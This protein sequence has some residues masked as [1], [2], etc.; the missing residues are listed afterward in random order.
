MEDRID[1]GGYATRNDLKCMDGRTIRKDAFKDCD[2]LTVPLVWQH[3]HNEPGKVLGHAI[4]ENRED[5]VY[6]YGVFNNTEAGQTARELVNNGDVRSLSIYANQLKQRGGD[7]LHGVIREV[8]LVLAG[9][10]PGAYIDDLS[11]GHGDD[12]TDDG[13]AIIYNNET[14]ELQH[15]ADEEEYY[16][17]EEYYP[18][19]EYDNELEHSSNEED[20]NMADRTVADIFNE[21]TDE[22]KNVVY[23]MVGQ[24]MQD[25]DEGDD[26]DMKHNVFEGD[27]PS[28]SLSHADMEMIFAD[29]KRLG[30][31]R[32]AV[33][34]H[35]ESG[36]LAHTIYDRN[37]NEVTYGVADIDYLFPE[38]R[39]LNNPPEFIRR[40]QDWVAKVMSSVH[41]TPFSRIKSQ[42]ANIT[43]D[44]ARAKGYI[45]GKRKKEEVFTLLKRTTDPQ[46]IYKK[47]KLDR[48]D[49]VDITDFDVVAWI[50]GEMRTMLNEELARAF[51]VGDG[52]QTSDEDHISEDHVRPIYHED[53][54]YAIRKRVEE[55][56]DASKTAKN[57]IRAAIKARKDYKG[58]GN[59]TLFTTEDMLTDMLLIED[60]I[61]HLLYPTAAILATTL[62]VKEIVTVPVM[63][64]LETDGK[65]LLGIIVNLTDYNVGADKGGEINM[66]DDFDIDYN[67]QKYLI[68]TRCSGAL[69]K[70]FSAIIL[71]L[72]GT[73]YKYEVVAPEST[74]NPK[75]EGWYEKVGAIYMPTD[76]TT[77][78]EDKT[79]YK[80]VAAN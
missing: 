53:E 80:K 45:K 10:N 11:F 72:N 2:G 49:I 8:S 65:Q 26:E 52:R 9:A 35:Q 76:D 43:M 62:R 30:S 12:E 41:H 48:D 29:A 14:L 58:T 16:D 47:Q 51:L 37:D 69:T 4:L 50:K 1:F 74:D 54:L 18:D 3:Q 59:P 28:N 68:E 19:E 61:G 55:G 79:Y 66:F 77:V 42:F 60:G 64:N 22:Q 36:V 63:E 21:M 56:D 17:D 34:A 71:E 20:G 25:D 27:T 7:V 67:Q 24:A 13:E 5:G 70:P 32:D 57:F 33:Q 38:A 31:L 39:S 6:T 40:D 23:Y 46:T 78:N 73:E 15:S 75:S 44:E